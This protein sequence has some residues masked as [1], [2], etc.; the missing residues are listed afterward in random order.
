MTCRPSRDESLERTSRSPIRSS[1]RASLTS[2]TS[3][4]GSRTSSSTGTS[5][6][7]AF[8]RG[9]AHPRRLI[10]LDPRGIGVSERHRQ[11]TLHRSRRSWTTWPW[12]STPSAHHHGDPRDAR[13]RFVA[14][15]F[16]ATYPERTLRV[17]VF[18]ASASWLWSPETPWEW[19][20][21]RFAEQED[22][23]PSHLVPE[24][25]YE[26][27]RESMPSLAEDHQFVEWSYRYSLLSAHRA[28]HGRIPC[29]CAPTFDRSCR[30]STCP[31]SSSIARA[32]PVRWATRRATRPIHRRA[33]SRAARDRALL[34]TGDQG[35]LA[36]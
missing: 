16:A 31:C 1:A 12:C 8:P 3:R 14:N 9:L 5:D 28:S 19:T 33:A 6:R 22:S 23:G 10:M 21:Q 11:A 25:A 24:A 13:A 27:V 30:P 17:I 32:T 29:T 15:M 26:D 2:S 34:W 18:E 20:E 35:V 4:A 36:R 7:R